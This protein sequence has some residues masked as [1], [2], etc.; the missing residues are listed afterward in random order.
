MSNNDI[1]K[2]ERFFF[3]MTV[4][5]GLP[6]SFVENKE[7]QDL[8]N[9]IAPSLNLPSRKKIGSSILFDTLWVLQKDILKIAQ[10]DKDGMTAAFDS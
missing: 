1:S 2:F 3:R 7:T 9:F 10:N 8:F 6:F 5:N 4:S